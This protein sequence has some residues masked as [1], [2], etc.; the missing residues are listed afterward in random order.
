MQEE[1]KG[2]GTGSENEKGSQQNLNTGNIPDEKLG[3]VD[4]TSP[5]GK[6]G[7]K[8]S[9]NKKKSGKSF[10]RREREGG[11]GIVGEQAPLAGGKRNVNDKELD[12][13]AEVIAAKKGRT[14]GENASNVEVKAGLSEQPCSTQ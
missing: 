7:N 1:K 3:T 12:A 9:K 13:K 6:G 4:P 8:N 2:E 10:K 14:E 11:A 5:K